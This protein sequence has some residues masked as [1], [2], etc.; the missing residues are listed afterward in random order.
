MAKLSAS[1]KIKILKSISKYRVWLDMDKRVGMV[2]DAKDNLVWITS[3]NRV[4]TEAKVWADYLLKH[5][6]PE[7]IKSK[8]NTPNYWSKGL[9]GL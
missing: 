1:R 5:P 2:L 4:Y 8:Y 6:L 9:Q 7:V 3:G